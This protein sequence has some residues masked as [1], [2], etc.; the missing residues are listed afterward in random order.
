MALETIN[1]EPKRQQ[2][3]QQA[4]MEHVFA[5]LDRSSPPPPPPTKLLETKVTSGQEGNRPSR[6]NPRQLRPE[7]GH[8]PLARCH[9]THGVIAHLVGKPSELSLSRG[10]EEALEICGYKGRD[11]TRRHGLRRHKRG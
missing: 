11:E 4:A 10:S 7:M 8:Y 2:K 1:L 9:R 5:P 6:P 3:R